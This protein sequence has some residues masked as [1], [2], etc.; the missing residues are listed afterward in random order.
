LQEL[1]V[2][3]RQ[4]VVLEF[5]APFEQ[6]HATARKPFNDVACLFALLF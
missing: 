6:R 3:G 1:R 5:P 4:R 2:F